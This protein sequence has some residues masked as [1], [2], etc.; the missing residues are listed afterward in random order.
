MKR[1]FTR[2]LAYIKATLW[3]H[4]LHRVKARLGARACNR[5]RNGANPAKVIRDME[6]GFAA[7]KVAQEG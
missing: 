6:D 7:F 1:K 4:S 3:K 5:L 2:I